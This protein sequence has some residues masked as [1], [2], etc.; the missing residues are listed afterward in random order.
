LY[1]PFGVALDGSGRIYVANY[2]GNDILIFAAGTNGN[3]PPVSRIAGP[4][5]KLNGPAALAFD[6]T[7]KLYVANLQGFVTVYGAGAS[8]N[9]APL[10]TIAGRNTALREP[11]GIALDPNQRV[12]VA[13]GINRVEVFNAGANGNVRPAAIIAGSNTDL[14]GVNDVTLLTSPLPIAS[15]PSTP[16]QLISRSPAIIYDGSSPKVTRADLYRGSVTQVPDIFTPKLLVNTLGR[17][18]KLVLAGTDAGVFRGLAP[19]ESRGKFAT[20]SADIVSVFYVE[21][22]D[23]STL[24]AETR[25]RSPYGFDEA[26]INSSATPSRTPTSTPTRTPTRTPTKTATRTPTRTATRRASPS[27]TQAVTRTA[28]RVPTRTTLRTPTRTPTRRATPSPTQTPRPRVALRLYV[29]NGSGNNVTIYPPNANGNLAPAAILGGRSTGISN[30]QSLTVDNF[31]RAYVVNSGNTISITVYATG[32]AGNA[33][34]LQTIAGS[35]TKLEFPVG[36][37]VDAAGHILVSNV[38][39]VSAIYDSVLIFNAGAHGNQAPAAVISGGGN[40]VIPG[41]YV[42]N[43][44]TQGCQVVCPPGSSH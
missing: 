5:T 32:A 42:N 33:T 14:K 10:R 39:S 1:T 25:E 4:N 44:C 12:Y 30:P 22:E 19:D 36:I 28:T 29:A 24:F 38:S 11:L 20:G 3:V 16:L 9:V 23:N 18:L 2:G 35:A 43:I 41:V 8:G 17:T 40:S 13:D 7:G 21:P 6:A 34:P 27:P 15:P 31:G 37:A 26:I